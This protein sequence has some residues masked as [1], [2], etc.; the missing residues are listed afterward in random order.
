M[1]KTEKKMSW[2]TVFHMSNR[3]FNI[4]YKKYP[5]MVLSRI[6]SVIWNALTPYVGIYLSA[7][8][9]D[10][11]VGKRDVKRLQ[12]LVIITLVSAAGIALG[13]ALLNKWKETRGA[14]LWLKVEHI[15]SEKMLDTDYVNLDDTKTAEKLSAIRQYMNSNGW[16][17]YQVIGAYEDLCSSILTIFGGLALAVTLFVSKVPNSAGSLIALNHPLVVIGVIALMLAITFIAPVLN[18]KAGSYY[19]K[20]ADS[21]NLGNRLF[22]FF[23]WLGYYSD[24]ATDVRMYRQDKICDRYNRNKEDTFGSNG[25]FARLARGPMGLYGAASAAVSV[26]FTGVVY[27]FV[28]L[29]A[30]AGAFGLGSV[31]QY[32]AAITKVS[33]GMSNFVSALGLMRNNA[34]FLEMNFEYLDIPNNMYKGSLTVEKRRDR[35]YQVEFRGVSFQYPGSENYALRNVNMKFE[36]GK[37]LA[38]V[39]MNGSGKTT[40]IKLLCRLYD[41]TEGEI[42]LNGIDIRKYNY[43]EYMDIFSVVFQDFKLL[44]LKLGENVAS[45]VD[46]DKELVMDCLEKAGFSDRFIKMRDG[47]ETYLYK[48]YD[49]DGVDVSGGEAQKIAIARA[50]YKDAPFIILDE[51]TAALDPIA[52]ADIYGKFDEIAG[53]KTA[54]YISHRLSSCRFCD[55][56]AVFDSGS[57][58]QFGTH[59]ELLQ[60]E[61]GKYHE[62]WHAQAQYYT[63]QTA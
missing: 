19:A 3:A 29:K 7:L 34:P 48:D 50:L 44:S 2:R 56:I 11:L 12:M 24:L 33:G 63:E 41:P 18:N 13:T 23:G 14:G 53:D 32:I 61:K 35:K 60:D 9:I 25:L 8:V 5:Q 10:E 22:S 46:Y 20:Y 27:A 42:L 55:R 40:F 31:T 47:T 37:R 57:V 43:R 54:I 6:I 51:P 52:E 49:K 21:H 62:L 4:F 30:L 45:K 28:C 26:I 58:V 1:K 36:I 16:G 17:L 15:F 59:D 38:V 39:G